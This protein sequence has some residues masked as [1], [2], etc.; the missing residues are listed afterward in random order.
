MV[1]ANVA[2]YREL[3]RRRIPKVLFDY[4]DGGSYTEHTLRANSE[5]FAKVQLRQR[6]LVDVSNVSV[7]TST[8]QPSAAARASSSFMYPRSFSI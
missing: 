1:P 8:G 7:K 5:D 6:V 3:A 2:D 4:V